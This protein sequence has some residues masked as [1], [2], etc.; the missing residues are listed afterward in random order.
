MIGK[1]VDLKSGWQGALSPFLPDHDSH[2]SLSGSMYI[3]MNG[4]NEELKTKRQDVQATAHDPVYPVHR[5]DWEGACNPLT[6]RHP[7]EWSQN[8]HVQKEC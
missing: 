6:T 2:S 8:L 3:L 4:G 5:F 7:L 1:M